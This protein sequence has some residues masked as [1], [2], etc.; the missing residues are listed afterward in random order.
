[1]IGSSS[2]ATTQA[3][4]QVMDMVTP[5][6]A[7][8]GGSDQQRRARPAGDRGHTLPIQS[9]P[10]RVHVISRY[11]RAA[12]PA[13]A[14]VVQRR[15]SLA[16]DEQQVQRLIE[17]AIRDHEIRVAAISGVLGVLLMIGTWHAIWL[18]R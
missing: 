8:R 4:M 6:N 5:A 15:Y 11:M 13:A 16:M 12:T 1:M 3:V 18:S 9:R 10:G 14:I 2:R 17:D 7:G